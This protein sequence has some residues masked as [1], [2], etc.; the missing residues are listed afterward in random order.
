MVQFCVSCA[1][2]LIDITNQR[3]SA[4]KYLTTDMLFCGYLKY[5]YKFIMF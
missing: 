1:I 3:F 4:G 2:R 5:L